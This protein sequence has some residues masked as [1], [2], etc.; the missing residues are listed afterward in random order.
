M[1]RIS[2]HGITLTS[3]ALHINDHSQ[4]RLA[5]GTSAQETSVFSEENAG[6]YLL[7]EESKAL[8]V[9]IRVAVNPSDVSSSTGL[10]LWAGNMIIIDIPAG[11]KVGAV[12]SA[13]SK[14]LCM[15]RV[16]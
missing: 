7:W 2:T 9:Y 14:T 4:V 6:R 5:I 16:G 3:D 10:T 11:S 12:T 8:D 1:P 13:A 15:I